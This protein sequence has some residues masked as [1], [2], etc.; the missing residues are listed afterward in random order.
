MTSVMDNVMTPANIKE[1]EYVYYLRVY[2]LAALGYSIFEQ[3]N[4]TFQVKTIVQ[5]FLYCECSTART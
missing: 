2:V 1:K 5:L 3:Y 4:I